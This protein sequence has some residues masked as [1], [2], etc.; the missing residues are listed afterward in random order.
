VVEALVVEVPAVEGAV[1][2]GDDHADEL[3]VREE[4]VDDARVLDGRFQAARPQGLV[5]WLE[6]LGLGARVRLVLERGEVDV[7]AGVG[8]GGEVG[9]VVEEKDGLVV[10]WDVHCFEFV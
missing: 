8:A 1:E 10:D 7:D 5:E 2:L 4:V 3:A 6:T 9:A